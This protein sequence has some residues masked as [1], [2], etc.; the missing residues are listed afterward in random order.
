M[1]SAAGNW[2]RI[3]RCEP[4]RSDR[5]VLV[6][7]TSTDTTVESVDIK[8]GTSGGLLRDNVFDGSGLRRAADS[9][10]DVKG[11]NWLIQNNR[12]T[13]AAVSGFQVHAVKSGWGN[14]N[15]FADNVADVRGSGY[16]FE[17]RPVSDNVVTCTNVVTAAAQGFSNATCR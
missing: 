6:G 8:E 14:G 15:V 11:N 3:S 12:G 7:N 16:G 1:G 2:C 4:D 10:V 13:F 9:W 17:L 5:N